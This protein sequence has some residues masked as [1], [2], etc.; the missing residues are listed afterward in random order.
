MVAAKY[1]KLNYFAID[2]MEKG[3]KLYWYCIKINIQ[4]FYSMLLLMLI[5][6]I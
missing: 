5:D 2:I 6:E 4:I 1:S 3:F